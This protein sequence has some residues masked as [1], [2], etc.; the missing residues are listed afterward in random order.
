AA[1][2]M[3]DALIVNPF[4]REETSEALELA[5]A[6]PRRERV[7]RWTRLMEGVVRDDVAAWRDRFVTALG[8]DAEDVTPSDEDSHKHRGTI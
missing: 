4:S 6:M 8:G 1:E 5:L 2:Q 7:A 3:E